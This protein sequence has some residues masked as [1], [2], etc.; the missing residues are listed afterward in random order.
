MYAVHQ[1][2]AP[3]PVTPAFRGAGGTGSWIRRVAVRSGGDPCVLAAVW[4]E[5]RSGW[6]TQ[7]G[8][9]HDNDGFDLG[10]RARGR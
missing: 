6:L 5:R 10:D 2:N 7:Q 1:P 4:R 9:S 3:T 8:E